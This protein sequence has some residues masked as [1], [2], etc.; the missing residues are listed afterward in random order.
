MKTIRNIIVLIIMVLGA[1]LVS[2][3]QSGLR[4]PEQEHFILTASLDWADKMPSDDHKNILKDYGLNYHL[5]AGIQSALSNVIGTEIKVGYEAFPTLYGGYEAFTGSIGI[6]LVSGYYEEWQYYL[7]WRASKVY[8]TSE[9]LGKTYRFNSGGELKVTRDINDTVFVGLRAT[10]EKANDQ[11]IFDW[12]VKT[13]WGAYVVI[14]FK[15]FKL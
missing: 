10:L 8:R 9:R 11:E 4:V 7:G 3:A 14:G 1:I 5:E 13:R 2:H 12:D 15:I 6:R